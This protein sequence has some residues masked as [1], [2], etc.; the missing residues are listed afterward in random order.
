[1]VWDQAGITSLSDLKA[2]TSDNAILQGMRPDGT[3]IT[4]ESGI[5]P[6]LHAKCLAGE[7]GEVEA[8]VEEPVAVTGLS[9]GRAEL[10]TILD[11]RGLLN[12]ADTLISESGLT[13]IQIAW[14]DAQTLSRTG[15]TVKFI[16]DYLTLDDSP[17]LSDDDMDEI[18]V[19]AVDLIL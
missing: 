7:F 9:V 4:I 14:N 13:S 2:L 12:A 16:V 1:M 10:K 5:D 11:Q 15:W 3:Y 19:E 6:I 18:F 17:A 8:S